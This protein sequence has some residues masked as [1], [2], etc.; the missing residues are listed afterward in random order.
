M[1]NWV[2]FSDKE[3][4][5]IWDEVYSDFDF[6]PSVSTFLAYKVPTPYITFDIS[7][8][9]GES[10]DL[11]VYDDLEEKV[12]LVIKENTIYNGT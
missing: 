5:E 8:Y 7:N 4:D 6:S 10:L 2:P 12:L 9:F 11:D 1:R 3:Y